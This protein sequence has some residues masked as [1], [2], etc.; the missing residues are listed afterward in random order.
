MPKK[1]WTL[2][3]IIIII[4]IIIKIVILKK[5]QNR[6]LQT[7]LFYFCKQRNSISNYFLRKHKKKYDSVLKISRKLQSSR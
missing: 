5:K 1:D 7:F 2:R 4:I 3:I 6:V